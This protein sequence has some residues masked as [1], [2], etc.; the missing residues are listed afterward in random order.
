MPRKLHRLLRVS[1]L[2]ALAVV[3][4]AGCESRKDDAGAAPRSAADPRDAQLAWARAALE[5]NPGLQVLAVDERAR[6]FTVRVQPTGEVRTVRLEDIVAAPPVAADAAIRRG[7]PPVDSVTAAELAAEAPAATAAGKAAPIPGPNSPT[8]AA[9][10][11]GGTP[12]AAPPDASASAASPPAAPEGGIVV[13][14]EAGKVRI[15]GPGVS[16]ASAESP[17]D[18]V[19]R[20]GAGAGAAADSRTARAQPSGARRS[21]PLICQ[22]ERELRLDGRTIE[23]AGNAIVVE[24]GCRLYVTNARIV[25]DDTAIVAR[26]GGEVHLANS[27]VEGRNAAVTLAAGSSLYTATSTFRGVLRREPGAELHDLG[28]NTWR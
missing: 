16:I 21:E 9:A 19:P 20:A 3:V 10:S 18:T 27:T 25:A 14:R 11:G 23:A 4:I 24:L 6:I 1:A 28:N 7:P 26:R 2:A 12:A 5:R 13:Q 22:G 15:T 17:G 8:S